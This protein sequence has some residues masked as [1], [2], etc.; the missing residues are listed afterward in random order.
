V[1]DT[2]FLVIFHCCRDWP[3]NP[4]ARIGKCGYC[5]EVPEWT[6]KTVAEYMAERQQA[7]STTPDHD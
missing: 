7:D 5:G 6:N 3:C 2:D 4:L 1:I